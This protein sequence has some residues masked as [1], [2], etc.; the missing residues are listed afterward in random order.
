MAP[1]ILSW[2]TDT[3]ER[4]SSSAVLQCIDVLPPPCVKISPRAKA[5]VPLN[6]GCPLAPNV[7]VIRSATLFHEPC[8]LWASLAY[9]F[10]SDPGPRNDQCYLGNLPAYAGTLEEF[11]TQ[12]S[13]LPFRLSN[14]CTS[15]RTWFDLWILP[16]ECFLSPSC[17]WTSWSN[18]SVVCSEKNLPLEHDLFSTNIVQPTILRI[19]WEQL[20]SVLARLYRLWIFSNSASQTRYRIRE[21]VD[22]RCR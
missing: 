9:H 3:V 1:W 15:T 11:C 20:N 7:S 12:F 6:T 17:F 19:L 21:D 2:L 16:A 14:Q 5:L 22:F 10:S 8:G 4:S 13:S 18:F